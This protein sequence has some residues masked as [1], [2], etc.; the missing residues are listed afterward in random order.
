MNQHW[1]VRSIALVAFSL[2]LSGMPWAQNAPAKKILVVNGRATEVAVAEI[3]GQSY[4]EVDAFAR[5]INGAVKFET[6]RVLLT[7]PSLASAVKTENTATGLSKA[8]SKAGISQL[9][10]MR[11]WKAAIA[12]VIRSGVA[13]GNWLGPLLH[14]HRVRAEASLGQTSLAARTESDQK[15]LQ[16]LKNQFTSMGEWDGNTQVSVHSLNAESSI[17]P[18]AAANDPLL[19]KISECGNFLNAMLVDGEFS[20]NPSCH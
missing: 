20:D 17:S 13:E 11:E 5:I 9:A 1:C 16:L 8:F 10:E 3:D 6:G 2:T 7:V 19:A 15:A 12:S 18:A 4:I 14:D